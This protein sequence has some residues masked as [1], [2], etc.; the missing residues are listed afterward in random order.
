MSAQTPVRRRVLLVRHAEVALHWRG[1]C[2]GRLDAGLSRA[3]R[4]HSHRLAQ[5]ILARHG[6]RNIVAVVH[7]GQHRAAFL[8]A[9]IADGVGL[10]PTL[11]A[12][13]RERDFGSWEGRTWNAIWRESGNAMERM[14]T[15][16]RG[17]RPGGGETT[18]ELQARAV[19]AWQGL[20]A[21]GRVVV[22][23]HGGPIACL[24]AHLAGADLP[25][26]ARFLPRHGEIVSL[27]PA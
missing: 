17:F 15:D 7:S 21:A 8:A 1:R 23:A 22:V 19:A 4:A 24:R 14:L 18:A 10:A 16:P 20:P 3:G 26:L 13:W 5:E 27:A 25:A 9:R 2:Y 12:R 6:G 11:D